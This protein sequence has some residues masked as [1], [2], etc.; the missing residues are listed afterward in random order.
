MFSLFLSY[1]LTTCGLSYYT[2]LEPLFLVQKI[3]LKFISE[4]HTSPSSPVF[5]SLKILKLKD[6]IHQNIFKFVL[7]HSIIYPL[8]LQLCS[9]QQYNSFPWYMLGSWRQHLPIFKKYIL[10]GLR[11]IK[12]YGAKLWNDIALFIKLSAKFN[13]LTSKLREFLINSYSIPS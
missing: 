3:V 13:S 1:G 8:I 9:V 10:Y 6:M 2:Y 11:S 12:S 7:S 5:A 4:A